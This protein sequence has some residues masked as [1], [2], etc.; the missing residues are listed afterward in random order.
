MP[1]TP[2]R[3]AGQRTVII[4]ASGEGRQA[5]HG[6][7]GL[8]GVGPRDRVAED[9]LGVVRREAEGGLPPRPALR[10][11]RPAAADAAG[12][13]RSEERRVGKECRN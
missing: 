8:H 10:L 3:G 6:L 2:Y 1:R 5:Q 7:L 9:G 13:P 12:G 11:A 4:K